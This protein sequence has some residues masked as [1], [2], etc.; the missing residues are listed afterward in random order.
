MVA[1]LGLTQ[2][3][4][5]ALPILISNYLNWYRADCIIAS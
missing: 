1:N 2:L 3:N 5:L 4:A